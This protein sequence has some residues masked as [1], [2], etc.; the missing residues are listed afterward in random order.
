[1][2]LMSQEPVLF[3]DVLCQVHDM[4]LPS[5]VLA[6]RR[7]QAFKCTVVS[8]CM[9]V[10]RLWGCVTAAPRRLLVLTALAG[11]ACKFPGA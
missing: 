4:L 8:A 9:T 10:P 7:Q 2:E 3:E 11:N 5:Q 1:M 6:L